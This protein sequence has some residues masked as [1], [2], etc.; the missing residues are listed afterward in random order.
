MD[1]IAV[2]KIDRLAPVSYMA[3]IKG[4]GIKHVDTLVYRFADNN[5]FGYWHVTYNKSRDDMPT[6]KAR[7]SKPFYAEHNS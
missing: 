7:H 6:I 2:F 3:N 1:A 5:N 4:R